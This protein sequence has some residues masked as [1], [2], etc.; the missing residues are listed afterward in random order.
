MNLRTCTLILVGCLV[1]F[2]IPPNIQQY[3]HHQ[4]EFENQYYYPEETTYYLAT[5]QFDF[6]T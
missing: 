2:L 3:H 4:F 5:H 6:E 1:E